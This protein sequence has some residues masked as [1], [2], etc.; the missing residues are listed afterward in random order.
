MRT[1]SC[2]ASASTVTEYVGFGYGRLRMR[3]SKQCGRSLRVKIGLLLLACIISFAT[4]CRSGASPTS[5][6][7]APTAPSTV[8]P[9]RF[10][11]TSSSVCRSY[12]STISPSSGK[13]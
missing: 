11:T 10:R 8:L 12:S 13:V 1:T 5:N 3:H 9:R 2:R 4:V 6:S 7:H